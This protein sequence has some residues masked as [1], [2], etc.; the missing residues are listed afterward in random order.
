MNNLNNKLKALY[1]ECF[2]DSNECREYLF[3]TRLGY[4]NAHYETRNDDIVCAM[5]LV[6]K[7]LRY[8]GNDVETPFI[9]ALSTAAKYRKQGHAKKLTQR[10]L[11]A[12]ESPFVMLY[13]DVKG[14]YEKMDFATVSEDDI[15]EKD[16][17][18][19]KTD[20][21]N[22]LLQLYRQKCKDKDF[23]INL[24]LKDFEDKK[25]II[26]LDGGEFFLVKNGDDYVGFTGGGETILLEA[27][28]K[29]KGVMA[30]ICNLEAAFS[31]AKNITIPLKIRLTDSLLE[32]NNICFTVDNGKVVYCKNYDITIS[33]AELTAHFFGYKGK[34]KDYF[35]N[36]NGFIWERY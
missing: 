31:L 15:C 2:S 5:Y 18:L 13:P 20:E 24:S 10:A 17:I 11:S 22:K 19:E 8:R 23:F 29:Q 6:N 9:V 30:R 25:K 12:I 33:V 32:K 7:Q 36:L 21:A 4:Q 14:F 3:K 35:E 27:E 16:C 28:K 34:L 1:Q 26:S